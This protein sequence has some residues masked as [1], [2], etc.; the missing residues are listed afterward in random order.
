VQLSRFRIRD[1]KRPVVDEW[2]AWIDRHR[3]EALETLEPERMYVESIFSDTVDG[4]DYLYWYTVQGPGG[5]RVEDSDHSM[6]R[7]HMEYFRECVD[8]SVPPV[9][10]RSRVHLVPESVQAAM[11]PT[12]TSGARSDQE[13]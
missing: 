6:D 12:D 2:M 1:G 11:A 3:D 5:R 9:V 7:R 13:P 10:L 8:E 4:V